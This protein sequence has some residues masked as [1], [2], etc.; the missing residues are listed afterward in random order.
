M[1]MQAEAFPQEPAGAI[2]DNC[3]AQF[4]SRNDT[5]PRT[6]WNWESTPV[7]N[8]TTID[9]AFA[10]LPNGGEIPRLLDASRAAESQAPWLGFRHGF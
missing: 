1:L 7:S 9:Q 8:E 3:T 10:R 4:A 6:P 5:K 2:A